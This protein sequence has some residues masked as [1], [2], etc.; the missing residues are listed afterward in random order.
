MSTE[1]WIK[2]TLN[3]VDY[4]SVTKKWMKIVPLLKTWIDLNIVI[5]SEV[6]QKEKTNILVTYVWNLEKW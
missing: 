4:Y 5:Q 3:T 6:S 2:K 1:K